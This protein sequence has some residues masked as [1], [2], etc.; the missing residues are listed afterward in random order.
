MNDSTNDI[1]LL[2]SSLKGGTA[3]F[4]VLVGRYQ[5]LVC[6]ITYG[7][8][9][10]L[11]KS[12]ELAQETF[13]L[14]WKN[15]SQLKDL[16][17]FKAWLCRI[18]KRV[19]QNWLRARQ[20]DVLAK[21]APIENG[22]VVQ[23]D[24]LQPVQ[25]AID[26]EQQAVVNQA[27][28]CI[29]E[30]YRLPLILFYRENKST[31]EVGQ[32]IGLSENATR[33]RIARARHLL[34][35]QVAAMVETTLTQSKPGKAFATGV[36]ASLAGLSI[37]GTT[38]VAAGTAAATLSAGAIKMAAF[39]AGLLVVAG[40]S[41]L[42][43][44]RAP[45]SQP[46]SSTAP[47]MQTT[48]P[49]PNDIEQIQGVPGATGIEQTLAA[50]RFNGTPEDRPE[51]VKVDAR[52]VPPDETDMLPEVENALTLS[53]PIDV[54]PVFKPQGVLSGLITCAESGEPV[55]DASVSVPSDTRRKARTDENGFYHL[56]GISGSGNFQI[57]IDSN[58][59]VGFGRGSKNPVITLSPDQQ[60]VQ[61]FQLPRACK[62][63]VQVVDVNGVGLEGIDVK[64]TS[65]AGSPYYVINDIGIRQTD[66]NGY[67]LL[68]GFPPV[69][70]DYM[71]TAMG[72]KAVYH[73]PSGDE[74]GWVEE[75]DTHSPART[76][77]RLTDPNVTVQAKI[78]LERGETLHG[79]VEYSDGKPA[80]NIKLGLQPAWWHSPH[81]GADHRVSPDGTFSIPHIVSGTYDILMSVL[82]EDGLTAYVDT[83][84]RKELSVEDGEPL[85]VQL[86][87]A[88]PQAGVAIRGRLYFLGEGRPDELFISVRSGKK[89]IKELIV[90]MSAMR[91]NYQG[92]RFSV[93]GLEAGTYDLHISG[94]NVRTMEVKGIAAPIEN[95]EI[96][97]EFA[98]SP[99]LTGR[100]IDERTRKPISHFQ[101]RAKTVQGNS[102]AAADRWTRFEDPN[103]LFDLEMFR[104]GEYQVQ[105]LADGYAPCWSDPVDTDEEP[106]EL[107]ISLEPGGTLEGRVVNQAGEPV[108]HAKILPHSLAGD[109]SARRAHLF[110]SEKGATF[111]QNGT[112]TLSHVPAGVEAIKVVH[113]DYTFLIQRD[114]VMTSEQTTS[115]DDLVLTVGGTLEGIVLDEQ[116]LPLAHETLCFCDVEMGHTPDP[117]KRWATTV[118]DANG[119]YYVAH[120]PARK[121]YVYR[122]GYQKVT[123]V[124]RRTIT[125]V[126]GETTRLDF[127]GLHRVT[128]T[129]TLEEGNPAKQRVVIG[130]LSPMD[131][132]CVSDTDDEGQFDFT[133]IV[134]GTYYLKHHDMAEG[135]GRWT[136]IAPV[137]VVDGDVDLGIVHGRKVSR[138]AMDQFVK[139]TQSSLEPRARSLRVQL[140][141]LH[142]LLQWTFYSRTDFLAG[143][144]LVRATRANQV[145]EYVIFENGILSEGWEPI[146]CSQPRAGEIYFGFQS[147]Q[148]V[149]TASG[150]FLEIEL[151]VVKDLD[152]IGSLQTGILPAGLYQAEGTYALLTDE[153]QVPE[154]FQSMPQEV[155]DKIREGMSFIAATG[156]W[157]TYWPLA[158]TSEQGWLEG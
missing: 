109:T 3:S 106:N 120:L 4:E 129:L 119:C 91:T 50:A 158:I 65:L 1:E 59:Y 53:E 70:T 62:V 34:K 57:Y 104:P 27:L 81:R 125:P 32:L 56:D 68:G 61:H 55:R 148:K 149:V 84:T 152:G 121:C 97:L 88:S 96:E 10:S 83:V 117:S 63:A 93:T 16:T 139:M 107:M 36:V 43:Y 18:T 80:T 23:A 64:P 116:A 30:S 77:V 113:P 13:L 28:E 67:V 40:V 74:S 86:P 52:P 138:K 126:D 110:A 132:E 2:R 143:K 20:R 37:K 115:L 46:S 124:T 155:V 101:I 133:G 136:R 12:E 58:D 8:T 51:A 11:D 154:A 39:A 144:L 108:S 75:V 114:I 118:T 17:K 22:M 5:S 150:D 15:L 123:G 26:R 73:R 79:Y 31:R 90:A 131:F 134:P 89:E 142:P 147:L 130:S 112:F 156:N 41:A 14:A 44:N 135:R 7:A 47:M 48:V 69:L 6:A 157:Q 38:A 35:G 151:H 60:V 102:V 76:L 145:D 103:G 71:I 92:K 29:P 105:V 98:T 94:G 100:V 66:S 33:Q 42:V 9:L 111:T 54:A 127:G 146:P 82:D 78:V 72:E 141:L 19:I 24:T 122:D 153:G 25:V 21:A 137:T 140:P 49:G 87:M 95:L 85:V 128:G 45:S 99:H